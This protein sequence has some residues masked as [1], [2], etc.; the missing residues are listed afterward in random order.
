ME[1]RLKSLAIEFRNGLGY[2]STEPIDLISLL[3]RIDVLTVF[4]PLNDDF[5]GLS[6]KEG[7]NMFMMVNS[8]HSIGRQ[9]F[10]IGHELYHLYYDTNFKPHRCQTGLFPRK[11]QNENWA[12]IFA[13][14]LVLPTDGISRMIPADEFGKDGI[15]L[16]TI[17]KIEQTFRSS[18]AAL[19]NQLSK[20]GLISRIYKEELSTGV[21]NGAL[22]Y[23][24]TTELYNPSD[25]TTVLGTYGTLAHRLYDDNKIS[26]G[27]YRELLMAIGVDINEINA[28]EED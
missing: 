19:L 28:N 24:Y 18:R 26:E 25:E 16:G 14:N 12:D 27:H 15:R 4:K 1:H 11:N 20:M 7:K 5:S 2:N 21:K 3:Q 22:Q 13:A 6:Y 23:G 8:N 17:L 9:N 10:T